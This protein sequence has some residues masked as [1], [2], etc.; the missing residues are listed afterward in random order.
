MRRGTPG[1][2]GERLRE[3]REVRGLTIV[4]LSELVDVVSH[5]AISQYEHGRSSPSAEVVRALGNALN[6]P[7]DFFLRPSRQ[8]TRGTVF[9]RSMSSATKSARTRA[10]RRV[11][12]LRDLTE[13]IDQH[14]T[15][16][17]VNIPVLDLPSDPLLIS[18]D[19]IEDAADRLR[20]HWGLGEAPVSNVVLFLESQ[21]V[22]LA[23]D[24]LMAE[25]LDSLSVW[26]DGDRPYM[27]VGVDKGT[28]VRWRFDAAHELGHLLFHRHVDQ[29]T[30]ARK[31]LFKRVESQA[32]R[33][34]GAFLLPLGPFSDDLFGA[35][36]DAFEAI[37]PKWKVSMSMMI[38]RARHAGM[39]SDETRRR[40]MIN[41]GRKGY[42]RNEPYDDT[43]EAE[44]PRLLRRSVEL[45]LESGAMTPADLED[46][47]SLPISD[48]E[49]LT[50]IDRG[51][52]ERFAPVTLGQMD[53]PAGGHQHNVVVLSERRR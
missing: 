11:D 35:S 40:L 4:A 5:Q 14:V 3:A 24:H 20:S 22:I 21:G 36:L 7:H 38:T 42:R 30:L 44:H 17:A 49:T 47:V 32:H 25:S 26:P 8:S 2:V 27:V 10:E 18:D 31:E 16:P 34:A 52:L 46:S 50:G 1:F 28:P 6:V 37:K 45:I 13:V 29:T 53:R 12:W 43:M 41:L 39:I 23:R 51:Y 15:L 19:E 9:Y 33:F 48:I